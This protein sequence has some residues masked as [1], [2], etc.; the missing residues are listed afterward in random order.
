[1]PE[2]HPLPVRLPPPAM[3]I[4]GRSTAWQHLPSSAL[5]FTKLRK[6]ALMKCQKVYSFNYRTTSVRTRR[7]R[8]FSESCRSWRTNIKASCLSTECLW[9]YYIYKIYTFIYILDQVKSKR[10]RDKSLFSRGRRR[11][12]IHSDNLRLIVRFLWFQDLSD[13]LII[14]T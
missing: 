6:L 1:M 8:D 5:N 10:F 7:I 2:G 14:Y 11:R 3:P 9:S 12:Y 13:S 4:P